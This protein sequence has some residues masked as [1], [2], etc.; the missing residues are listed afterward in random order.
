MRHVACS[1]LKWN[2]SPGRVRVARSVSDD[3]PAA[4]LTVTPPA[5]GLPVEEKR[6]DRMAVLLVVVCRVRVDVLVAGAAAAP[7]LVFVES[8]DDRVVNCDGDE[9]VL[10]VVDT[11]AEF[12]AELLVAVV[13]ELTSSAP[14][15]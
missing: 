13:V 9:L 7:L 11:A 1:R 12:G 10:T 14:P 2:R 4:F 15:L 6:L 8:G 5:V 3:L